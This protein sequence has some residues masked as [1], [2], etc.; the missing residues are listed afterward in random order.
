VDEAYYQKMQ[1]CCRRFNDGFIIGFLRSIPIASPIAFP[2]A[3][4][5]EFRQI[6]EG[7]IFD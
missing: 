5:P 1:T 6:N 7:N 4:I 3:A 2:I